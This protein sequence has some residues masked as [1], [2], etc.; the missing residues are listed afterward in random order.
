MGTTDKFEPWQAVTII[1]GDIAKFPLEPHK[2]NGDG[3]TEVDHPLY[4]VINI[5][6]VD[7]IRRDDARRVADR[8]TKALDA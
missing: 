7:A 6:V 3:T 4:R 1:S 5:A 2:L 8:L